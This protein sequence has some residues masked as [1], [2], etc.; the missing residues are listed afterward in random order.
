MENTIAVFSDIDR[1][2]EPFR[3]KTYYI[4]IISL[5]FRGHT[6]GADR[7]SVHSGSTENNDY[8]QRDV[9]ETA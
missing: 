6:L 3:H 8:Y 9:F 2:L 4:I 1:R 7:N 5:K